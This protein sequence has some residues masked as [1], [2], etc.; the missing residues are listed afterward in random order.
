[1]RILVTG[2]TGFIGSALVGALKDR[3]HEIIAC[4]H[5]RRPA[6]LPA[7]VQT[8]MVDYMRDTDPAAWRPRLSGVDAV[9]NAVGILRET[10]SVSFDALHELAPRALFAACEQSGV[11]RV[12]QV[13][14]LGADAQATSHYHRS[15]RA[16]DE[17][18][19]AGTLDW[20]IIQPSIVFGAKGASAALFLTLASLPVIPLVGRGDQRMQPVHLDD[21]AALVTAVVDERLVIHETVAAVGPESITLRDMLRVYR[22]A[23]R[24][25]P[26]VAVPIPLG[27]V[28]LGAWF[29]DLTGSGALSSETLGMLLR[30]NTASPEA[31]QKALRRAPRP[32]RQFIAPELTPA[33]RS[34]ALWSWLRP[35][36]L[37]AIAVMWI[38]A[39]VVSW[40]AGRTEGLALLSALGMSSS[41]AVWAFTAACIVDVAFG[42][43]TLLRPGRLLWLA[44]LAVMVFYTAALSWVAPQLWLD[45]FGA[46][47]KNLPIAVVLIGLFATEE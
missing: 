30:H 46:L 26:T 2:A 9:V 37:V 5:R 1:M 22:Q 15:K 23:L 3:G 40:T 32:L 47:V 12:I 31:M 17:A 36:L 14:A 45:P 41:L 11:R 8:V 44:Q 16:A 7:D 4:V 24:L 25:H 39:G 18:L 43:A 29:G 28:R 42:V 27:F 10:R 38:T 34:K 20:T 13:S 19:R 21:L 33:L 35:S 6:S